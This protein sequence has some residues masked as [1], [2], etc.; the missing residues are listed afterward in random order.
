[1]RLFTAV[2]PHPEVVEAISE[3]IPPGFRHAPEQRWHITLSFH[4]DCHERRLEDFEAEL[5]DLASQ[6]R[7]FELHL[8]GTGRFGPI[9]WL[10]VGGEVE[11]LE[12]LAAGARHAAKVAHVPTEGKSGGYIPH[13][14]L[15]RDEGAL[16]DA[17]YGWSSDSWV[18]DELA[19]V[20]S[21]LEGRTRHDVIGRY[22]L[23][24]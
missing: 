3:R 6:H 12:A 22:S 9:S 23:I 10:G 24:D 19:L 1:M 15:G 16:A 8:E 5:T 7:A 13:L 14:T 18:V 21:R 20:R 17:L 2:Y 4:P 11:S